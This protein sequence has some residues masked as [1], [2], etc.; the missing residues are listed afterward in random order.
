MRS[1]DWRNV[2]VDPTHPLGA[3]AVCTLGVVGFGEIGRVS[4]AARCRTG[5]GGSAPY[6]ATRTP[7]SRPVLHVAWGRSGQP[8]GHELAAS[9]V[10]VV[11]VPL[12]D[13]SCGLMTRTPWPR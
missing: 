8:A 6:G 10:V 1:G 9:D 13:L 2:I 3:L 12:S 7:R 5:H 4:R 11:T